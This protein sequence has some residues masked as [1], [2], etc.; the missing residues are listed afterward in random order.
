MIVRLAKLLGLPSPTVLI[1]IL[2]AFAVPAIFA[3]VQT[4]R[5]NAAAA[6]V[7]ELKAEKIVQERRA[8]AAERTLD[9]YRK[10]QADADAAAL[11]DT[12]R[13]KAA[14]AR[15]AQE[16]EAINDLQKQ[17]GAR[18]VSDLTRAHLERVR[19]RQQQPGTR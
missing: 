19:R 13:A 11:M 12:V 8:E 16:K 15:L 5:H 1:G 9:Q 17:H 3:G 2:I 7:D 14:E 6:R 10:R 18:P 4:L